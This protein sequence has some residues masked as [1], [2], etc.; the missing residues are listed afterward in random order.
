MAATMKRYEQL[1][2]RLAAEIQAGRLAP[3]AR[4]PS[5]RTLTAQHGISPSTAFQAYYRLEEKGLVHARER[6]GYYVAGAG[7]RTLAP[8]L[9]SG[10]PRTPARVDV[11]D[12]VFSV[13]EAI[14]HREVVP[15]GSA[16]PSATLFPMA[17]L[18]RSLAAAA[19]HLPGSDLLTSFSRGFPGLRQQIAL[20][21]GLNGVPPPPQEL[22][23]TH[24]ALEALNLCLMA[25]TQPG[26]LVAIESPGFYAALQ[27]IERLGL[28]ALEIPV[29]PQGGVDLAALATALQRHPVKACWF[30][31]TFQNPMGASLEPSWPLR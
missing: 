6:S 4:L 23:V 12:L 2:E 26:D 27:A 7:L 5:I 15:L 28:R 17:R 16:F 3:D 24:G 1:A 14:Q 20:R 25:V 31:T 8:P 18:G 11:N 13:L 19:R 22:I 10:P 9:R 30:M 21:Y 29:D